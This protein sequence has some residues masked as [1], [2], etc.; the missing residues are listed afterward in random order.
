ME[1]D[2]SGIKDTDAYKQAY[3]AR[4][5]LTD[6]ACWEVENVYYASNCYWRSK[7]LSSLPPD[8]TQGWRH[9][10]AEYGTWIEGGPEVPVSQC[11]S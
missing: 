2:R 7:P 6:V 4:Y 10:D 3:K 1:V 8:D 5:L 9:G 11:L